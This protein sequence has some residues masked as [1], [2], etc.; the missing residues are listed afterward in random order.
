[1]KF[2]FFAVLAG[3]ALFATGCVHTVSDTRAFAITWSKDTLSNRYQRT[4]DQVYTASVAVVQNNGVLIREY[5]TPG[6]NIVRSLQAKVNQKDVWIRVL[7]VDAKTTEVDVQ[8]RSNWG[9][10]DADLAHEL[11][12]EIGLQLVR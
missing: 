12:T 8:A 10:S 11:A 3:A 5:I 4:P 2:K 6:T 7:P 9:V 1:M